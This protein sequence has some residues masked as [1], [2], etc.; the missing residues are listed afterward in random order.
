MAEG[1]SMGTNPSS[2]EST[3]LQEVVDRPIQLL[4][5]DG[6]VSINFYF[7]DMQYQLLSQKRLSFYTK[8]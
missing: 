2:T 1:N 4:D 5:H 3:K 7:L 6:H 8:P